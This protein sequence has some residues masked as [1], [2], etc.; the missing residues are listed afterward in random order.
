MSEFFTEEQRREY[1]N[2]FP[3]ERS[4][5]NFQPAPTAPVTERMQNNYQTPY[6]PVPGESASP[7][8]RPLPP[9]MPTSPLEGPG[10]RRDDMRNRGSGKQV[11]KHKRGEPSGESTEEASSEDSD[12][13]QTVAL[14]AGE[15]DFESPE[16]ETSTGEEV[17]ITV[18]RKEVLSMVQAAERSATGIRKTRRE[19]MDGVY[20][21]STRGRVRDLMERDV[22]V[23]REQ[24][25]TPTSPVV[26]PTPLKKAAPGSIK[27]PSLAKATA[28]DGLPELVP[29]EARKVRFEVSEDEEMAE[30]KPVKTSTTVDKRRGEERKPETGFSGRQSELTATVDK[31][32][33]AFEFVEPVAE[34][35]E[36]GKVN[37]TLSSIQKPRFQ[38]RLS[39]PGERVVPQRRNLTLD[40]QEIVQWF[41]DAWGLLSEWLR[42]YFDSATAVTRRRRAIKS[43]TY[44]VS[45]QQTYSDIALMNS[46][47]TFSAPTSDSDSRPPVPPHE[48]FVQFRPEPFENVQYLSRQ[49][50]HQPPPVTL[51]Q[52]PS[53]EDA[54]AAIQGILYDQWGKFNHRQPID[55]RPT[56]SAAPQSLYIG[57]YSDPNGQLVHRSIAMNNLEV[58]TD[59][60]TGLPYTITGHTVRDTY[61]VPASQNVVWPLELIYPSNDRIRTEMD[62]CMN[63]PTTD[64]GDAGF[65]V[66]ASQTCPPLGSAMEYPWVSDFIADVNEG[67]HRPQ[68]SADESRPNPASPTAEPLTKAARHFRLDERSTVA[69]N[70][71]VNASYDRTVS[72]S[73]NSFAS[74]E[75]S[76]TMPILEPIPT[77]PPQIG[78]MTITRLNQEISGRAVQDLRLE[79]GLWSVLFDEEVEPRLIELLSRGDSGNMSSGPGDADSDEGLGIC[80]VCFEP[81]HDPWAPCA[82]NNGGTPMTPPYMIPG[83][84]PTI[85]DDQQT[86]E[87]WHYFDDVVRSFTLIPRAE[88]SR[89]QQEE[90]DRAVQEAL[91]PFLEECVNL[92]TSEE[93]C[94]KKLAATAGEARDTFGHLATLFEA[95]RATEGRVAA[96]KKAR[97]IEYVGR[98]SWLSDKI[99]TEFRKAARTR[100][101]ETPARPNPFEARAAE[102]SSEERNL[103]AAQALAT[104]AAPAGRH[105]TGYGSSIAHALGVPQQEIIPHVNTL[106]V[107][108]L[109]RTTTE[110]ITRDSWSSSS[111]AVS[112]DYS[113][114]E[115]DPYGRYPLQPQVNNQ[116]IFSPTV[117]E[118]SVTSTDFGIDPRNVIDAALF[119]VQAQ[120]VNRNETLKDGAASAPAP[121]A[122][123]GARPTETIASTLSTDFSRDYT[124]SNSNFHDQLPRDCFKDL[125]LWAG[126]GARS[127]AEHLHWEDGTFGEPF[128]DAL[129]ILHGPLARFLDYSAM[130]NEGVASLSAFSP[131]TVHCRPG[132]SPTPTSP[133]PT[134]SPTSL[135]FSLP[136]PRPS[137]SR[138]LGQAQEDRLRENRFERE[139]L[140]QGQKREPSSP[141]DAHLEARK[142]RKLRKFQGDA[143][144]RQTTERA[145]FQAS[146]LAEPDAVRLFAGVRQ[147]SLEGARRVEAAVWARYEITEVRGSNWFIKSWKPDAEE[148]GTTFQG[149]FP[150]SVVDH[151]FLLDNETTRMH[152]LH[153]VLL[154]NGRNV[155]A[156]LLADILTVRV[157]DHY[158]VSNYLCAGFLD[159]AYPP[160]ADYRWWKLLQPEDEEDEDDFRADTDVSSISSLEYLPRPGESTSDA[161]E[162]PATSAQDA[163]D[164][165]TFAEAGPFVEGATGQFRSHVV[166]YSDRSMDGD[167]NVAHHSFVVCSCLPGSPGEHQASAD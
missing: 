45:N 99:L 110:L 72:P 58:L 27:K 116:G 7:N 94:W 79:G 109:A 152:A 69:P 22:A 16:E 86:G 97:E 145:A 158:I 10:S 6:G 54:L 166:E 119:R 77:A 154:A 56:F 31:Q 114:E 62:R 144:R 162:V 104:L 33:K 128:R 156:S 49:Q 103:A 83:H 84:P 149:H 63:T 133:D 11:K 106:E 142:R 1:E 24:E 71:T 93:D 40:R 34:V 167:G 88:H 132:P 74:S 76:P 52:P 78:A 129:S 46:T 8:S 48:P 96:V 150:I 163:A 105:D 100:L 25:K 20:P 47:N 9:H 38:Q 81:R 151:P 131:L 108:N 55:V 4:N 68:L 82:A 121:E 36:N 41:F 124:M 65:P 60:Q 18:P 117:S 139:G 137:N 2:A 19:V 98:L 92:P 23:E 138:E 51:A 115:I 35:A 15:A 66:H 147:A 17:Y 148:A 130:A 140:H 159:M 37:I 101:P 155:L 146:G 42:A 12:Q 14:K 126:D 61:A 91:S 111:E 59:G 50:F 21:P 89:S 122:P 53:S 29:V 87:T 57:S 113:Y 157:C 28:K 3:G 141:A 164:K 143:L 118:W 70:E 64:D 13:S 135:D 112:T 161:M 160:E 136:D 120:Q 43:P 90:M 102:L 26:Q 153:N 30:A 5:Y 165:P 44:P 75:T 32:K 123:I 125:S 67:T 127:R 95:R 107:P 39:G 85:A 80:E 134:Q 73:A